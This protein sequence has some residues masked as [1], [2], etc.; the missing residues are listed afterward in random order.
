[1]KKIVSTIVIVILVINCFAQHVGINNTDPKTALD[2]AGG[3][4]TRAD[5]FSVTAS[6]VTIPLNKSFIWLEGSPAA[7]FIIDIATGYQDGA[8]MVIY[9]STG[10]T[11]NIAGGG[12]ELASG[13]MV[14]IIWL[15]GEWRLTNTN[16]NI[17]NWSING[18]T[19]TIPAFHFIG[20]TDNQPLVFR[21][22]NTERMRLT[23]TG[24]EMANEIK[25]GGVAGTNGQVLQSNGDGTM[26]WA[27]AIQSNNTRFQVRFTD[28]SAST[29]APTPLD[30]M[31]YNLNT[32]DV[33]I[34]VP[35]NTFTINKT[36]LYHFDIDISI[37]VN[38][39]ANPTN[40]P[41]LNLFF[42]VNGS[43]RNISVGSFM[44]YKLDDK[45]QW[46]L[47]GSKSFDLHIDGP[48]TI[49]LPYNFSFITGAKTL[50]C[51]LNGH[52]ISE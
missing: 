26:S 16:L 7:D 42:G 1:M 20:N 10:K 25:P 8:R 50:I 35:T 11:G 46:E 44:P 30:F 45:S 40:I 18:N 31:W 2:I 21:T 41:F 38:T 39:V 28:L 3:F 9:N 15:D 47:R 43:N 17:Y 32:T 36:G 33:T 5:A 34:N 13:K 37:R 12:E 22:N 24:L 52:L 4:R 29:S 19:G 51:I 6:G 49:T 14:E 27:N 48:S 23:N